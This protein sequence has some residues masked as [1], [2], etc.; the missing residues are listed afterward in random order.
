MIN[1]LVHRIVQG[2]L[3]AAVPRA[4]LLLAHQ[5]LQGCRSSRLFEVKVMEGHR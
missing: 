5:V 4:R 1:W 3:L 2:K